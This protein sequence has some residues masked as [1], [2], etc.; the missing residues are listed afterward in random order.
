[1]PSFDLMTGST[2]VGVQRHAEA[3]LVPAG[4]RL[5]QRR[6][7]IGL[8][9]AVVGRGAGRAH[10]FVD[11]VGRRRQVGVAHAEADDIDALRPLLGYFLRYADEEIR[12]QLLDSFRCSHI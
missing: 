7:A 1:M 8:R 10:Q 3:L 2:P 6:Q 12:R 4:D 5:A 11:D 9:I